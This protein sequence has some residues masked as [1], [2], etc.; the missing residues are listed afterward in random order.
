MSNDQILDSNQ[1]HYVQQ[2]RL[3]EL[4]HATNVLVMGI[5]SMAI[6]IGIGIIFSIIGIARSKEGMAMYAKNPGAYSGYGRLKTGRILSIVGIFVNILVILYVIA[7]VA[8]TL[9]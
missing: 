8:I 4:P 5:L 2:P 7:V 1:Q 3:P 6:N 9:S